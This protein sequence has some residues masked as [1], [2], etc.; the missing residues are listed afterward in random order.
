[1]TVAILSDIHMRDGY[2]EEI[3]Q[4]LRAVLAELERHNPEHA[5]VL[6]DLIEDGDSVAIDR[7]NVRRVHTLLS[8]WSV[9]VT[10][11]LGNHDVEHLE[12]NKLGHILDQQQ[13]YGVVESGETTFVYLDTAYEELGGAMGRIGGEQLQWLET[14]LESLSDVILL[15][16]HPVGDFDLAENE[17]FADYPERAYLWERKEV[18]EILSHC[19]GVHGTISGHIHQTEHTEF[20]GVSHVS[21]NAFSKELPDKPLTGTYGLLST[22]RTHEI[23]I[24]TRADD[25]VS[26]LL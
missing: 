14:Q 8:E 3:T 18:L 16:H 19:D 17:W 5:F 21:I 11:L 7:E 20:W 2:V 1:M 15:T 25:G 23:S 26:Y 24:Q 4:E 22:D 9:P 6:G 10:Y 12:K 13:F